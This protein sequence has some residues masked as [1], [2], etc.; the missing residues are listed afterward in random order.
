L[1]CDDVHRAAESSFELAC[2]IERQLVTKK[3]QKRSARIIR[4]SELIT[5]RVGQGERD[6]SHWHAFSR[7]LEGGKNPERLRVA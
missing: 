2:L 6:L 7:W 1:H 3:V 5:R 4:A